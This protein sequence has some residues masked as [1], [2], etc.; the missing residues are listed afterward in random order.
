ML[1][2]VSNSWFFNWDG[3]SCSSSKGPGGLEHL[4]TQNKVSD[5]N[6]LDSLPWQENWN[7]T[8][9]NQSTKKTS[10]ISNDLF[11]CCYSIGTNVESINN[12]V[13]HHCFCDLVFPFPSSTCLPPF[14]WFLQRTVRKKNPKKKR[15]EPYYLSGVWEHSICIKPSIPTINHYASHWHDSWRWSVWIIIIIITHIHSTTT[16]NKNDT[17]VN[18]N[19]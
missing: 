5:H 6:S 16:H 9:T 2:F 18:N 14:G 3:W 1:F 12:K 19:K 7:L 4:L 10:S 11:S 15:A 13:I 17:N 8:R